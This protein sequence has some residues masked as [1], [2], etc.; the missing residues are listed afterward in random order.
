MEKT[1]NNRGMILK[2]ISCFVNKHKVICLSVM[3]LILLAAI[4]AFLSNCV[5]R[6]LN[7]EEFRFAEIIAENEYLN[8]GISEISEDYAEKG[9]VTDFSVERNAT[10]ITVKSNVTTVKG[11]VTLKV[12]DGIKSFE[13]DEGKNDII[14]I[15]ILVAFPIVLC[16]YAVIFIIWI[17]NRGDL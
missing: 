2:Q 15:S 9:Y 5:F 10:G 17:I 16:L 1:T 12:Y 13:R 6:S 7:D 3:A 11:E 14:V 4:S 8:L